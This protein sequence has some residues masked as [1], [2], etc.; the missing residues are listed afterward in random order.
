LLAWLPISTGL[1]PS[2]WVMV[3][4]FTLAI[5]ERMRM[6]QS[7]QSERDYISPRQSVSLTAL[8]KCERASESRPAWLS[9]VVKRL[10]VGQSAKR[11][12]LRRAYNLLLTP[13]WSSSR[14]IRAG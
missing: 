12:I 14:G 2:T 4:W 13:I 6:M 5:R 3:R 11:R 1:S 9:S 8:R 10:R 7:G